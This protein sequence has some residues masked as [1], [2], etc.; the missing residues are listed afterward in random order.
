MITG[1][2]IQQKSLTMLF[3]TTPPA[4]LHPMFLP[5]GPILRKSTTNFYNIALSALDNPLQN[6]EIAQ[7]L[8]SFKP[9]KAPGPD[10]LH[11]HFFQSQW[12]VVGHSMKKMCHEVF[13]TQALPKKCQ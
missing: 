6:F 2:P 5:I 11:P 3:L 9:F 1:S 4:L 13:A 10:G 7:A 12:H 8:F